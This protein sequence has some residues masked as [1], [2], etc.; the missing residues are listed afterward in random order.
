MLSKLPWKFNTLT[1]KNGI[2][3]VF[4]TYDFDLHKELF[5][6]G[7]SSQ[8]FIPNY[9][10]ELDP[11]YLKIFLDWILLGDGRHRKLYKGKISTEIG[12]VS[13]RLA[14]DCSEIMTKLGLG[15]GVKKHIPPTCKAPDYNE[16]GRMILA[17]NKK[18]IYNVLAS[19]SKA[20]WLSLKFLEHEKVVYND[21]LYGI[22][23]PAKNCLI[24][25]NGK[26]CW[27]GTS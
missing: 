10:K 13:E 12:V 15:N 14:N 4:D 22:S 11:T 24:R 18:P 17:E 5:Q 3:L 25:Q 6:Y 21:L 9:I 8:K 19:T 20:I 2:G 1:R 7:N 27:T 23:V 26:T 16:T